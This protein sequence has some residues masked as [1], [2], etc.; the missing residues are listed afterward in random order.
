L[1]ELFHQAG[2]R[3]AS[4]GKQHY[5]TRNKAFQTEGNHVTA[6]EVGYFSY[7]PEFDEAEFD[8]VKYPPEPYAWIFGGRFPLPADRTS[9]AQAVAAAKRWLQ[10]HDRTF[11][12]FLR[13]SF[14]APH[15]PVSVPEPFDTAIDPDAIALP[16]EADPSSPTEARWIA[17]SLGALAKSTRLSGDEIRKMRGYY[18]GQVSFVDYQF[19]LLLDWMREEGF[20]DNT[21]IAYV[22]DHGT[23]LGDYG[24]VQKQTFYEPAAKV[25]YF[26]WFPPSIVQ[27]VVLRTPVETRSLLPTLLDLAGLPIPEPLAVESLC[28]ALRNGKEPAAK[29]VFSEFTL[30]SFD[31][32][33]D[34]RLVM[35]QDGSWKLSL[36]FNPDAGDG[37][38]Y[39]LEN[40]P[41]ERTNLYGQEPYA[42]IQQRLGRLILEHLAE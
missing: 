19:G 36:C 24:L 42:G 29:P 33:H 21:I 17:D 41:Y 37:A 35:V 3:S 1:T 25:P 18:Y 13:V 7:A 23:H 27:G 16:P 11:P 28:G 40:D 5:C 20:L 2:Y 4:F 22:S 6:K 14:N 9:E 32:R 31:I 34:D 38:L 26:F 12:F 10:S 30:G 39:N 8:V 15:T